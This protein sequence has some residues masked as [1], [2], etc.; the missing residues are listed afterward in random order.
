MSSVAV[1]FLV[2][3]F[4][5]LSAISSPLMPVS[6]DSHIRNTSIPINSVLADE[7]GRG[8]Q[9][10]VPLGIWSLP[11]QGPVVPTWSLIGLLLQG[12]IGVGGRGGGGGGGET[13]QVVHCAACQ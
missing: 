11:L 3:F 10:A 2:A 4:A 7:Q 6:E 9:F 8:S 13:G 5:S 1:P 12:R